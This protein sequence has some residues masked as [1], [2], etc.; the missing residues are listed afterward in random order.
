MLA[1]RGGWLVGAIGVLSLLLLVSACGEGDGNGNGESDPC[2]AF[3]A[4]VNVQTGFRSDFDKG[5]CEGEICQGLRATS[6]PVAQCETALVSDP[7]YQLY[8]GT[9]ACCSELVPGTPVTPG[10][11]VCGDDLDCDPVDEVCQDRRCVA[12]PECEIDPQCGPGR[13]CMANSCVDSGVECTQ[14]LECGQGQRCDAQGQC[15]ELGAGECSTDFDC[16]AGEVC[17][18][19]MCQLF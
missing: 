4:C 6:D 8:P 12:R 17:R 5:K 1:L 13:V 2:K 16:P 15:V 10:E 19:G 3:C 7:L 18:V 9:G 11:K 14:D